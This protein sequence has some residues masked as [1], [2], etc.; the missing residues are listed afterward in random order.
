MTMNAIGIGPTLVRRNDTRSSLMT[1]W[2]VGRIVSEIP[3]RMLSV[4][5]V[6]IS[7]GILT[8]L[9]EN[10]V[11]QPEPEPTGEDHRDPGEDLE[12][13]GV[14]ADQERADHHAETDHRP[15]RQ[16]E[17]PDEDRVRLGDGGQREWHGQ[18]QDRGDVG[19]VDEAVEPVLGVRE[20]RHDQS[21]TAGP[22]ASTAVP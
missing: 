2:A 19:F 6:A 5:N 3:S 14:G 9:N 18:Q 21:G 11:D 1:P 16:V 20:Q 4:A 10:G 12:R 15:D 17:I 8:P 13:R 22:P 7:D